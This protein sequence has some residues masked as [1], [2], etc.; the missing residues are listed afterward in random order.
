M[1]EH[2]VSSMRATPRAEPA[3][4][5]LYEYLAGFYL[6][7]RYPTLFR[8]HAE[9]GAEAM[10]QNLAS[11]E[12]FPQRAPISTDATMRRLGTLVDED[13]MLLMPPPDGAKGGEYT[14]QAWLVCFTSGFDLPPLLGKPLSSVHAP[15]PGYEEKLGLSMTRWFDRL[16]VGR[17]ARRYNWAITMRG[18]L[19]LSHGENALYADHETSRQQHQQQQQTDVDISQAHLR[20]E[21]Q[22]IFRLP[23]SRAVVLMYKTYLYPLADIRAEGQGP[24]LADAI[25]G[26]ARGNAPGMAK[27]KGSKIWGEAVCRF[28]RS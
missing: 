20:T 3:V 14:M 13:F 23:S 18:G 16:E 6:P 4:R 17:L 12:I 8:S 7:K 27:Y 24:A 9:G 5:E 2:P 19:K 11:G 21:L 22:H 15:V 1:G 28:L 10:L 26:L 25:E